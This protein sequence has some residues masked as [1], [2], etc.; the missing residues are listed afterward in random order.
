MES[1]K[2]KNKAAHRALVKLAR[3][4][5][6]SQARAYQL[7]LIFARNFWEREYTP[8]IEEF[9]GDLLGLKRAGYLVDFLSA[10]PHVPS[11]RKRSIKLYL[12]NFQ[13]P[14]KLSRSTQGELGQFVFYKGDTPDGLSFDEI[15]ERWGLAMGL[16][17]SKLAQL[18][19]MQ[20]RANLKKG[21]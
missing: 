18:L 6:S 4:E 21:A 3:G 10:F 20:R 11:P 16:H 13:T 14:R 1:V 15:A 17:A 8:S 9:Q 12:K 19:D 7:V 5:Y 2:S